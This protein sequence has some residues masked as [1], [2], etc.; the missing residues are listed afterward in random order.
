MAVHKLHLDDLYDDDFELIAIHSP[1]EDFRL[2]YFLNK[3][4][5]VLFSK[6]KQSIEVATKDGEAFFSKFI[7]DDEDN[8]MQ[9]SLVQNKI[10]IIANDT[11]SGQDLFLDANFEIE[12][13]VFL[14]P[15]FKKVDY[16]LKI[17]NNHDTFEL[18]EIIRKINTIERISTVYTIDPDKIKSKNN[19]IF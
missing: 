11:N 19:L 17:E 8:D 14:I 3:N 13:S 1:L 10:E 6:S 5:P 2:A 15:E 7:F 9:W 12:T 18:D 4:L 16:F